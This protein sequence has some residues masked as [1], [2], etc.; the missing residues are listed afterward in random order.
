MQKSKISC[1]AQTNFELLLIQAIYF[2]T[3]QLS[4]Q[5]KVSTAPQKKLILDTDETHKR[6]VRQ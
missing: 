1:L 5:K 4:K 3:E 6:N 2:L